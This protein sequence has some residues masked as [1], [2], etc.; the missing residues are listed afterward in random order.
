[1]TRLD[2]RKTWPVTIKYVLEIKIVHVSKFI[3]H[4]FYSYRNFYQN[5]SIIESKT[6]TK[7]KLDVIS[8]RWMID[9]NPQKCNMNLMN[10]IDGR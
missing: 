1:M 6:A 5:R 10:I 9:E 7:K 4:K 8:Y 2:F 3:N